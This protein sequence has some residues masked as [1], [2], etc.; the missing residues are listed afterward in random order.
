MK[1]LS[2][3]EDSEKNLASFI[4]SMKVINAKISASMK[5]PCNWF[6]AGNHH[7]ITAPLVQVQYRT[8]RDS[9]ADR[10]PQLQRAGKRQNSPNPRN[11]PSNRHA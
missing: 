5:I 7:I 1:N 10:P 8:S 2:F 4:P 3:I 11:A 9:R 6:I